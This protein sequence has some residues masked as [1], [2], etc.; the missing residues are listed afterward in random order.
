MKLLAVGV[1]VMFLLVASVSPAPAQAT[2]Q[3]NGTVTDSSGA[4]LPGVTVTAVQ[5]ETAFR[6]EAVTDADGSYA[7][8]NLPVGPYRLEVTLQGFRTYSQTG[9]VLQVNSNPV[10]PVTLQV[11]SVE[12]TVSVEAAAPLVETRNP[13]IG[14]VVTNE[15]VEALPLEG[16]NAASLISLTVPAVDSGTPSSRSL[17]QS[18]SIAVAGGQSF[19]VAYVLDGALHNN[20][21]DGVGL[22]LP[23]PDALQE[24][25]VETSAQNAANGY[26]ASGTVGV[27]TKAG[28]NAF[29]GSL[30][31]FTR[32]HRFNSTSPF[33]RVDPVTGERSHD[34]L[35]RNQFGGVLGGP[36]VRNRVFF[37]V[38]D[39]RTRA[40][41]KPAD[42]I[43]FIP[44]PA[45]LAGDFSTVAS[46][47][48]RAQGNLTLPATLGF[49]NNRI[50]PALL[51]PAALNIARKLPTTTDPCGQI[52]YTRE[53]RPRESQPVARVD[54][55]VSPD[56]SLFARYILTTTT[57]EP[58]LRHQP[59]NILVPGSGAGAGGRDNAAHSFTVGDTHVLSSTMV[60]NVRVF[61]NRTRV[62]RYHD[63][64]FGP[65]DV[66]VNIF[67]S[68][69]N[70][71]NITTTGA[72]S[73]NTGTETFSSYEPNT[74]GVTDDVTIVRGSHQF[75][76][77]AAFTWSDWKMLANVRSMGVI[78][79]NGGVTGLPLADFML[80]RVFEFRQAEPYTLDY[81]QR[82]LGFYGQDTWRVS[83][84]V[85]VSY[86]ARWEPWFPMEARDRAIYNFD[87]ERMR[88][89]IRSEVFPQA[90]PGFHFPGDEGFPG[91]A[92]MQTAWANIAPRLG[93]S[94]DPRADG[95]TAIRAGYGMTGDFVTG[96]VFVE[97][98]QGPPF[99]LETRVVGTRLEDPWGA[100]GRVN[101]F[102]MSEDPARYDW[103]LVEHALLTSLDYDLKTMRNHTWNVGLQQQVGDNMAFSA[104]YMGNHMTNIW[105][106]VDGNPATI[107]AGASPTGPCTLRLP[108]GGTQTFP[109]CS[110]ANLLDLRREL[111]QQNPEIGRYVGYLGWIAD[112]GW[113]DYHGLM[114]SFQRR[115]AGGLTTNANYTISRCEGLI[116]QGQSPFNVATG[117]SRPV[118]LINPP[119]ETEAKA[120]FEEDKGRCN[121][122][123]KHILTATASI[124]APEFS[125]TAMR[126]LASGWRLSGIFR[127]SSGTPL[128]VTT[129]VDRALSGIQAGT[130]RANQVLDNPYGDG[131]IN[132]WLNP[133]AFAQPALGTYG[134]SV[135]N[136]YDGPRAQGIDLS[137]VRLFSLGNG[138][139]LEAR[140]EAFNAF[141]W[142]IKGN[143]NT[144]LSSANFGRIT[145]IATGY[146]PRVMQFAMRY[147][148]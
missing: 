47:Q 55:Q 54:W 30:F 64:L 138:R 100:V 52:A 97:T 71:M 67:T 126:I 21:F 76:V 113:Q 89:G 32:H 6:R 73:I 105:G 94:W 84:K 121:D 91:K 137:L 133:V 22:P 115:S 123:R 19:G 58:A 42:I 142:F 112:E 86:G 23:F 4:V 135:R 26:K 145:T 43:T 25:R 88:A 107:P 1:G 68:V 5:T 24:F 46:A 3:I 11:G 134:N 125:S 102:P 12:E 90:T 39:Q 16:R 74:Y 75:G 28:T 98:A 14:Q 127:A 140:V 53:T 116:N 56:N 66:G 106:I 10:M 93:I 87:V 70:Y 44:T 132:N 131:T 80:G 146:A 128:T 109:N 81:T 37:F 17:T 63:E 33:A 122:W 111:T 118:S 50:D 110:A 95:R 65:E 148:F 96:Q 18:R 41:E 129:G 78:S 99:G 124:Q 62:V 136:A 36:L 20:V 120:L 114:L 27:A 103:S 79:F 83:P 29:H 13:A 31:E 77:G 57:W 8:L 101:P 104:T 2:A 49:A 48:C 34:G 82:Y 119:S 130:Q 141:N 7:L 143:P 92:G 117:Y 40:T 35:V 108:T 144:T 45:M 9:I 60:N 147:V 85:T 61:L 15:Q 38:G 69:P 72:F 139:R 51:S 59:D